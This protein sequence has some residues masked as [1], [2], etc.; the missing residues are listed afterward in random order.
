MSGRIGESFIMDEKS[1]HEIV[2]R[3]KISYTE[4]K[5]NMSMKA[6]V[7]RELAELGMDPISDHEGQTY[8]LTDL[9]RIFQDV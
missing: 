2:L 5:T 4:Q 8:N 1:R 7:N 9:P 6:W 3:A